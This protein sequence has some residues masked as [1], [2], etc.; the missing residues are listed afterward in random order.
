[1][2]LYRQLPPELQRTAEAAMAVLNAPVQEDTL[3]RTPHHLRLREVIALYLF[4]AADIPY[5]AS[6]PGQTEHVCPRCL[7]TCAVVVSKP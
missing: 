6:W 1:M 5:C 3:I 2:R 4:H 7:E